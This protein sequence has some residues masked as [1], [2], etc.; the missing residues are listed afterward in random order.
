[1]RRLGIPF[2]LNAETAIQLNYKD[3]AHA[4]FRLCHSAI[5]TSDSVGCLRK[6]ESEVV[7]VILA[8]AGWLLDVKQYSDASCVFDAFRWV[9]WELGACWGS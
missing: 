1:M 9:L 8:A 5:F 6:T 4:P 2:A 3:L 7:I